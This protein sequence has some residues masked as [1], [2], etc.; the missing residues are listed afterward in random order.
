MK[1]EK[2][3]S[4]WPCSW[5]EHELVELSEGMKMSLREKLVWLE[6]ATAFADRL[7]AGRRVARGTGQAAETKPASQAVAAKVAATRSKSA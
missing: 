7:Q 5:E 1:P 3:I 4:D 6:E 2:S